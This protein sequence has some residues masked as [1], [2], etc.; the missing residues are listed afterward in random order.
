MLWPTRDT[1]LTAEHASLYGPSIS[2]SWRRSLLVGVGGLSRRPI[3][4]L[5]SKYCSS[6]TDEPSN[7]LSHD[8]SGDPLRECHAWDEAKKILQHN[9][10]EY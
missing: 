6:N 7:A 8:A 2:F 5:S 9:D 3:S 4:T 1:A 10:P